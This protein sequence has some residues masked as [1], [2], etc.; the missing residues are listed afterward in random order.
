MAQT[1]IVFIPL[2]DGQKILDVSASK[3]LYGIKALLFDGFNAVGSAFMTV[4]SIGG[5]DEPTNRQVLEQ[6]TASSAGFLLR[7]IVFKHA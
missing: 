2:N 4:E 1:H 5:E 6:N 7:K 3:F